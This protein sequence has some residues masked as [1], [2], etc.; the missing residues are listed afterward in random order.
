[1]K[2]HTYTVARFNELSL[3]TGTDVGE[4]MYMRGEGQVTSENPFNVF[5]G[6]Y[7]DRDSINIFTKQSF[8][9]YDDEEAQISS[10]WMFWGDNSGYYRWYEGRGDA[11]FVNF[12]NSTHNQIKASY[13]ESVG[14]RDPF[15]QL[16]YAPICWDEI[17]TFE[18]AVAGVEMVNTIKLDVLGTNPTVPL[19]NQ[20]YAYEFD[21]NSFQLYTNI[22]NTL[23]QDYF[24]VRPY[25]KLEATLE[26]YLDKPT[27]GENIQTI[28][29]GRDQSIIMPI[30]VNLAGD[31]SDFVQVDVNIEQYPNN[32]RYLWGTASSDQSIAIG[33]DGKIT[34]K[35][36]FKTTGGAA[37]INSV[38]SNIPV[39][40]NEWVTIK[41]TRWLDPYGGTNYHDIQFNGTQVATKNYQNGVNAALNI[42]TVVAPN[43]FTGMIRNV[44]IG[45]YDFFD[46]V[47]LASFP[48]NEALATDDAV[49]EIGGKLAPRV[50]FIQSDIISGDPVPAEPSIRTLFDSIIIDG[51]V[52]GSDDDSKRIHLAIDVDNTLFSEFP[53][54]FKEIKFDGDVVELGTTILPAGLENVKHKLEITLEYSGVITFIGSHRDGSNKYTGFIYD[55][56]TSSNCNITAKYNMDEYGLTFQRPTPN[57][58]KAFRFDGNTYRPNNWKLINK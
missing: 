10:D 27:A 1:M 55:L 54:I 36:R 52:D 46:I 24:E 51:G 43:I 15:S 32:T 29:L 9:A 11:N 58:S 6:N 2:R 7:L 30:G 31:D 57:V 47:N 38:T 42:T 49:D 50:N 34:L 48:L 18:K 3:K 22:Y 44:V 13:T 53:V 14:D 23:V 4:V 16:R 45:R 5:T 26:Y 28:T 12:G 35:S 25:E 33:S 41:I 8:P 37:G 21:K 19:E 40:M 17:T 20:R 56:A 39:P